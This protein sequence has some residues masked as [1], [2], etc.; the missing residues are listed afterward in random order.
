MIY[1]ILPRK[2]ILDD[3]MSNTLRLHGILWLLLQIKS[4]TIYLAQYLLTGYT[5]ATLSLHIE[6]SSTNNWHY[7]KA[8]RKMVTVMIIT[9]A[10]NLLENKVM[11]NSMQNM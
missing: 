4:S 2:C 5:C 11:L 10:E 8:T 1:V 3:Y 6:L 7:C 9:G